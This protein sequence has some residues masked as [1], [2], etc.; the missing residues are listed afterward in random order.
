MRQRRVRIP[1]AIKSTYH[2][3]WKNHPETAPHKIKR[4]MSMNLEQEHKKNPL[5]PV[6]NI[7]VD[8]TLYQHDL[9]NQEERIASIRKI[10]DDRRDGRYIKYKGKK[11]HIDMVK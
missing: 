3:A 7:S 5:R 1:A 10:M 9:V 6:S 11:P 2:S 4:K 8:Q